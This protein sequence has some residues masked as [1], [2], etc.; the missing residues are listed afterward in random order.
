[1]DI[2]LE[3][4]LKTESIN[5]ISV[6]LSYFNFGNLFSKADHDV[7]ALVYYLK[8]EEVWRKYLPEDN[9]RFG[10]L[11]AAI[12]R[13]YGDAKGDLIG[14]RK[15]LGKVLKIELNYLK[16]NSQLDSTTLGQKLL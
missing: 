5:W 15:F 11:Y 8:A 16:I 13:V 2:A 9:F 10:S 14:A 1:M 7:Q 6:G 4:R 3:Y 12:G